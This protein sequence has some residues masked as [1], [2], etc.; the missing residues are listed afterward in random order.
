MKKDS[1]FRPS[2][3]PWFTL[4]AGGIG[5]IL[6]MIL[7]KTQMEPGGLLKAGHPLSIALYILTACTL[8]VL[9]LCVLP[10]KIMPHRYRRPFRKTNRAALGCMFGAIG[11]LVSSLQM[12]LRQVEFFTMITIVM[13]FVAALCLGFLAYARQKGSRPHYLIHAG[14]IIFLMLQLVCQYRIWSPEPQLDLYFFPLLASVFLL[15]TTYQGLCLDI[16]KG[17]RRQYVFCNQAALFFCCLSL[18]DSQCFFYLGMGIF[19]ATNLCTLRVSHSY[20]AEKEAAP[21]E[22]TESGEEA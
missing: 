10:L 9:A 21:A 4:T 8:A 1:I 3:L 12:V 5:F 20:Y 14:I 13:A 19:C 22:T 18:M 15:L 7:L 16:L 17:D 6:R 2:I 11:I